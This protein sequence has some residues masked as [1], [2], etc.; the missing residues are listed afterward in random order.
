MKLNREQIVDAAL[1]LLEETGID[2]LTTRLIAQRLGVQQP[3]L[4]WHFK[5]KRALL[6]AMNDAILARGHIHRAPKPGQ[7]WRNFV[8]DNALSFRAALL[9]HRDGARVHAGTEANPGDLDQIEPQLEL[10]VSSGMPADVAMDLLL[11]VG[12][13]TVGCVLEEQVDRGSTPESDALDQAAA[14]YPLL[15]EGMARYRSGGHDAMFR[16][17]LELLI[18]GAETRLRRHVNRTSIEG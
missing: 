11:A 15:A 7:G 18:S 14:K 6:D 3:A 2:G 10:L 5:N 13:Y 17:G 12:R 9:A 1:E 8:R 4:Y 16:A